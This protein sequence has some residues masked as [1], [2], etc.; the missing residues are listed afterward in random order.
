MSSH[1][2]MSSLAQHL[3]EGSLALW[4]GGDVPQTL[5]GVPTCQRLAIDLAQRY[6]LAS[7]LPLAE[8]TQRLARRGQRW[9][10]TD[11]LQRTLSAADHGPQPWHALLAEMPV[12]RF[13]TTAY[14]NL[15]ARALRAG[16]RPF[17][18]LV[19]AGQ[20][21]LRTPRAV[22][23]IQ[24]YGWVAQPDSLAVTEN[25][26]MQ[27]WENSAKRAL[28]DRVRAILEEDHLLILGQ[29]MADATFKQLWANALGRLGSLTPAAYAVA[30]GLSAAEQ[31]VWEDRHVHILQ[32]EPLAVIERLRQPDR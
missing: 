6:G 18:H 8:A 24:L 20:V 15:L 22:S 31:A 30:P 1:Q 11:F 19:Q 32:D 14:D 23:L 10:F 26:H 13:I 25:D 12:S 9:E 4:V 5:T 29:D 16:S 17:D 2:W 3:A 21:A 27:L 7:S 28:L